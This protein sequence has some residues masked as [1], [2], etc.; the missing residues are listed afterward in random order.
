MSKCLAG[1][2]EPRSMWSA[3]TLGDQLQDHAG[4]ITG[5]GQTF[6]ALVAFRFSLCLCCVHG[7]ERCDFRRT[8]LN[9]EP[10]I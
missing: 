8:L 1:S 5:L 3:H 10:C 7:N 4:A 6:V 9:D 2:G